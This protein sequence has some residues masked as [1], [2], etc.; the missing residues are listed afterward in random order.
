MGESI[1]VGF[2]GVDIDGF[3]TL[4]VLECIVGRRA[5]EESEVAAGTFPA[6]DVRDG[7]GKRRGVA[8]S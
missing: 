8:G 3:Y 5:G 1:A 6:S 4:E 7:P 2:S